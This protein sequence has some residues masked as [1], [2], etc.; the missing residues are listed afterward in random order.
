[1]NFV[2]NASFNKMANTHHSASKLATLFWLF[3]FESLSI[4]L[5]STCSMFKRMIN[6]KI[7]LKQ[8][9]T[10]KNTTK[11]RMSWRKWARANN[12]EHKKNNSQSGQATN[13]RS[14]TSRLIAFNYMFQLQWKPSH[15]TRC[16]VSWKTLTKHS[17]PEYNLI[18]GPTPVR[19]RTYFA[20]RRGI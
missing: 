14:I 6:R 13:E 3:L 9:K 18:T 16:D 5:F 1:M 2:K 20:I 8:K 17:Q 4:L 11:T 10:K 7:E 15:G 12:N 19:F